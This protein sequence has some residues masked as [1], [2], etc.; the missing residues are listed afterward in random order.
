[1]E[2]MKETNKEVKAI[3]N[4]HMIW[5]ETGGKT[6]V[7]SY[8]DQCLEEYNKSLRTIYNQFHFDRLYEGDTITFR[9]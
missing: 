3:I 2:F 8:D 1:M 7:F 5:F 4:D 9:L 6:F